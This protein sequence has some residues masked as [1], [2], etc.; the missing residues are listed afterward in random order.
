MPRLFTRLSDIWL[1]ALL[2]LLL[3]AATFFCVV[4][5]KNAV[6]DVNPE[7]DVPSATPVSPAAVLGNDEADAQKPLFIIRSYD[8]K[9]AVYKNGDPTPFEVLDVYLFTLPEQDRSL[10]DRGIGVNSTDELVS[11]I[12]DYTG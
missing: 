2:I 4:G 10:L 8:G 12:E 5:I 1:P 7:N 9:I 3:A 6:N 11:L